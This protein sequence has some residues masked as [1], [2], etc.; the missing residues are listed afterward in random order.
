MSE[1]NKALARRF[2]LEVCDRRK[3]AVADEIFA[4]AYWAADEQA[5]LDDVVVTR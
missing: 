5:A 4:D 1:E 3:P 2:F